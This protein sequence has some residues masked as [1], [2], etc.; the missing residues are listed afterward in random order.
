MCPACHARMEEGVFELCPSLG[1]H[2]KP[3]LVPTEAEGPSRVTQGR[4]AL[5]LSWHHPDGR[6]IAFT[7]HTSQRSRRNS[8]D[9]LNTEALAGASVWESTCAALG[10]PWGHSASCLEIRTTLIH[11]FAGAIEHLVPASKCTLKGQGTYLFKNVPCVGDTWT[12]LSPCCDP[13][14]LPAFPRQNFLQVRL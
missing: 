8:R 5:V 4:P 7:D 13:S 2:W 3:S 14:S 6:G 12:G 11:L 1:G 9:L 10:W